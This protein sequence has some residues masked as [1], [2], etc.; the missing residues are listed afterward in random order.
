MKRGPRSSAEL[1]VVPPIVAERP[2]LPGPA[3]LTDAERE[4]WRE[5]VGA[6]PS[7]W[8]P[9]ETAPLLE[10]YCRHVVRSRCLEALLCDV[11]PMTDL[12]RYGKLSRLA[13]EET[14]R[15]LAVARSLRLTTQ[16]RIAAA[17]AGSRAGQRR[18]VQNIKVL[19][20]DDDDET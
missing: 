12:D 3:T 16:S 17:T 1:A 2:R 6:M 4:V 20:E 13:G 19:F 14:G 7:A 5:S 9:P 8:F 10:R 15:I 11:D 18:P